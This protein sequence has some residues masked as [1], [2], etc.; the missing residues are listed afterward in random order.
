ML[1]KIQYEDIKK[2]KIYIHFDTNTNSKL[3][4]DKDLIHKIPFIK[5]IG[6][7]NL[8]KYLDELSLK[9]I[10]KIRNLIYYNNFLIGYSMKNY[11]DYKSLRKFKRRNFSLKKED[12]FK[13]IKSIQVL[14]ENKISF[15]DC[16]LGNVL[17]NPNTNDIKICDIDGLV[18][19]ENIDLDYKELKN[20]L[21]LIL[22]YL[23]NIKDCDIR[24]YLNS[25][26]LICSNLF[27][28]RCKLGEEFLTV[29]KIKEI[30]NNI[31]YTVVIEERDYIIDKSI[32]L[33]KT[34]Y[35]KYNRF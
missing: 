15:F 19:K 34:G 2:Y 30:V 25:S 8:L 32:E 1:D 16:H 10:V 12:C 22:S 5:E 17:L 20:I 4:F 14:S 29:K 26:N 28:D 9:E 21:I 27:I 24:N 31:K 3:F 35:P 13:V 33:S 6:L 11:K 18:L 23:Y 7:E